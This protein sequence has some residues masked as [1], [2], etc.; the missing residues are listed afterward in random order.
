MPYPHPPPPPGRCKIG[1][2]PD[3]VQKKC[4]PDKP[5][6]LTQKA[7][8]HIVDIKSKDLRKYKEILTQF[9]VLGYNSSIWMA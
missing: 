9:L 1:E 5:P 7:V 8:R 4:V 3:P 6:A 2:Y